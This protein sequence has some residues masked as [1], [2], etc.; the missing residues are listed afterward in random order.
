[1]RLHHC[2]THYT[3]THNFRTANAHLFFPSISKIHSIPADDMHYMLA[4][5]HLLRKDLFIPFYVIPSLCSSFVFDFSSLSMLLLL[6]L[7]ILYLLYICVFSFRFL[8]N[9]KSFSIRLVWLPLTRFFAFCR[10]FFFKF[11]MFFVIRHIIVLTTCDS[12]NSLKEKSNKWKNK[13][14]ENVNR[15]C[16]FNFICT[17]PM[18]VEFFPF[19]YP[20]V[21]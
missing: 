10:D 6:H 14:K 17:I 19:I 13:F 2:R 5:Y 7:Y 4:L 11:F 12:R 18:I 1:M 8:V 21:L 16:I 3:S 20:F 9:I 15:L